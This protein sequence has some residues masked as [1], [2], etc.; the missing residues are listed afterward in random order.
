M[1]LLWAG[2][3]SQLPA[4][5]QLTALNLSAAAGNVAGASQMAG[6]SALSMPRPELRAYAPEAERD[7]D[8][9]PMICMICED[10]ATGLHY[11]IITCE[12]CK[13]FFQ[14][15]CTEP[16]SLHVCR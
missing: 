14:T 15:D 8:E 16:T 3:V 11:G 2:D 10:K 1:E 9:Q 5:Q 7:E 13:G 12:G 4:H 6:A